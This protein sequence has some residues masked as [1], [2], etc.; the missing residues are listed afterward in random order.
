M[1]LGI[2][3]YFLI[4][5]QNTRQVVKDAF[6]I[7]G[8]D[9][10]SINSLPMINY[11][12]CR[13]KIVC[14]K[15]EIYIFGGIDDDTNPVMPVEKYSPDTNTWDVVAQMYDKRKGFCACSFINGIYVFG[16]FLEGEN[17]SSCLGL[18]TTNKMWR[19]IA[20]MNE[21]RYNASCV[22]FEGK[23]VV[24]GGRNDNYI[25]LNTVEAYDHI[26]DSW[27]KMPNMIEEKYCH[28]S[29]AIKNKLFIVSYL[30]THTFEVFDSFSKKFALLQHPSISSRLYYIADVISIGNKI[31]IF[32]NRYGSVFLFDVEIDVWS[33]KSCDATKHIEYYSCASIPH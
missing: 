4:N 25:D 21:S 24:T 3:T 20:R 8:T 13:S 12:R 5:T 17:T 23:I 10:L 15:G 31:V 16:G 22:V 14:I 30:F 18:S 33:E 26:N 32:S 19:E 29:V 27:T 1:L 2:L 7:N 6:T 9:F 11:E 28:K